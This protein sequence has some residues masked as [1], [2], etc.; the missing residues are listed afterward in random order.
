[1]TDRP[2]PEDIDSVVLIGDGEPRN[3]ADQLRRLNEISDSSGFEDDDFSLGGT[4]GQLERAMAEQLGKERAIFM[5]TGTLA[6]HLAIRAHCN[7]AGNRGGRAAVQEQSH[8]FNDTGDSLQRLSGINLVPLAAGR[9]YFTA[10]ELK[11]AFET[12]VTGRVM[13]PISVVMVETPVRRRSGQVVPWD[14]VVAISEVSRE[15]GI[16]SHLD[17][18]RLFMVAAATGHDVR[19]Y[20][21]LFDSVYVS[22][23][24]FL[25][26]PFGGVLAGDD[27]F[28]EGMYH[29]RRMF[30][31]GLAQSALV[32]ALAL[33]GLG[34]FEERFAAALEKGTRLFREIDRIAGLSITP[35][36]HGSNIFPLELGEA[37]DPGRFT[38][39]LADRGVFIYPQDGVLPV[40]LHVNA[41]M[42]RRPNDALATA[43]A[44]AAAQATE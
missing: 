3:A 36:E 4:V 6:N 31:G 2:R 19:E 37:V 41:T 7:A 14:E 43:F 44:E 42:L 35:F 15:L 27:A 34:G 16:P 24:K 10:G 39:A 25:G 12:S 33:H 38:G 28:I 29:D 20:A 11:E 32:A 18:A 26:A 13:N 40:D 30:G 17:G 5:P 9:V 23:Y 1:M 8:L 21:G 22:L